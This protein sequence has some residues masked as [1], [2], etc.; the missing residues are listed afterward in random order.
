[1]V[2]AKGYSNQHKDTAVQ[3]ICVENKQ[4]FVYG[5]SNPNKLK[6]IQIQDIS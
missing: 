6:S 5:K 3:C 1:M 2:H 4:P